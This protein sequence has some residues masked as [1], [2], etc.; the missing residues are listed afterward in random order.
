MID[1]LADRLRRE[2]QQRDKIEA[3]KQQEYKLIHSIRKVP[4]LSLYK[5][6]TKTMEVSQVEHTS[7]AMITFSGEPRYYDKVLYDD[8]NIYIQALNM[9]NA[10]RKALK[11]IREKLT[12]AKQAMEE[13]G[14]DQVD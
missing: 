4:G 5:L 13:M 1:L 12:A 6:D 10:E 9:K 3:Q 7:E 8:K 11:F 14:D 2:Q